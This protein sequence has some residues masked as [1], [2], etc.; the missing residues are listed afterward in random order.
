M[1]RTH[2]DWAITVIKQ[3]RVVEA[4]FFWRFLQCATADREII[5]AIISE[6]ETRVVRVES[7]TDVSLIERSRSLNSVECA[8]P[9]GQKL[10]AKLFQAVHQESVLN[11][12]PAASWGVAPCIVSIAA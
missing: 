10:F 2:V 4:G 7:A 3:V 9:P 11:D 6:I 5:R 8:P 1:T 12:A